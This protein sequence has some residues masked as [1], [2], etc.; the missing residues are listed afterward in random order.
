MGFTTNVPAGSAEWEVG[1]LPGPHA[2]P[3]YVTAA[4]LDDVFYQ[5]P[6]AVHYNS[7]RLGVRLVGP[8]PDWVRP[9]LGP[10]DEVFDEYPELSLADWHKKHGVW[11]E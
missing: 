8:K 4:W 7:N 9:Q 10:R 5:Q 6:Y 3:D 11:V 1:S 2:D